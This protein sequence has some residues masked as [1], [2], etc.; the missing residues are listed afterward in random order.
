M[1]SDYIPTEDSSIPL[2]T[3]VA[4]FEGLTL[5]AA[6]QAAPCG[7]FWRR[8]VFCVSRLAEEGMV[9]L[10]TVGFGWATP[11]AV[12]GFLGFLGILFPSVLRAQAAPGPLRPAESSSE[13]QPTSGTGPR[14][15]PLVPQRKDLFGYWRLNVDDSDDAQEKMKEARNEGSVSSPRGGGNGGGGG[16]GTG[17][18]IHIGG[19]GS[20]FPGGGGGGNGTPRNRG[21][22]GPD[23]E[24]DRSQT[25]ELLNPAG[26]L[27]IAEKNATQATDTK[28]GGSSKDT[29][30]PTLKNATGTSNTDAASPPDG[31]A[32]TLK[33]ATG[34]NGTSTASSTDASGPTLKRSTGPSDATAAAGTSTS[35][36]AN[37]AEIVL[38]DDLGRE[39]VYYT[40]GRKVQKPKDDKHQEFDAYWQESYRLVSEYDGS[41][42][43]RVTRSFEPAP[44][45]KQLIEIVRLERTRLYGAV[46][47]RYVYDLADSK[48][49]EHK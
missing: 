39:R 29:S 21:N 11:I 34:S 15:E 12:C 16:N 8:A 27:T 19:M 2:L 31:S 22:T 18:P 10:K 13:S 28:D 37:N 20:P 42:G 48:L 38:T 6:Q 4:W 43:A 47:I 33:G 25:Q 46:E 9:I 14:T 45:G 24:L 49:I 41:H 32:P 40:D 3:A 30:A 23:S 35:S 36:D 1:R 5:C 7:V 26:S 17:S 44:G